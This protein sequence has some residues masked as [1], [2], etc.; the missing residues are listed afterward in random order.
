MNGRWNKYYVNEELD[1]EDEPESKTIALE[2][3]KLLLILG[4]LIGM[5]IYIWDKVYEVLGI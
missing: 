5:S 1:K 3:L 4:L 2:I